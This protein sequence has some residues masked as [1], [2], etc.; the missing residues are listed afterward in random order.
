MFKKQLWMGALLAGSLFAQA[1]FRQDAAAQIT[2]NFSKETV[3]GG[4]SQKNTDSAGFLGTYRYYFGKHHGVEGNYGYTRNTQQFRLG[5]VTAGI[6]ANT[7]ELSAAYVVRFP[8]KR[9]TPFALAGVGALLFDQP[10]ASADIEGRAAFVYGGGAD[11][12]V[13]DRFFIRAQYRGQVYNS[14]S[15]GPAIVV[16]N[17]R[18]SHLAQPS[19]G[20]GFR[21]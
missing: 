15:T 4:V 10:S 18:I 9:V 12:H 13:T 16:G 5:G 6:R 19:V 2:G 20:F 1:D 11:V 21:F 8:A 7:H 14:L 17:E 3:E